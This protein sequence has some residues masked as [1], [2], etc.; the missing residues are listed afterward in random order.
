MQ[1]VYTE[2][3]AN[4]QGGTKGH[5]EVTDMSQRSSDINATA[6]RFGRISAEDEAENA[7]RQAFNELEAVPA[8]P[9]GDQRVEPGPE[10]EPEPPEKEEFHRRL[11]QLEKQNFRMKLSLVVLALI[12]GYLS[13]DQVLSQ[14]TIVRQTLMESRELKLLDNDGN[15]RLFL[16]MYSR[17]PVLQLLDSSGKPRMSLG[18][19]FDDTPFIDLSDKR[20]RTRATLELTENDE[21]ALRL[22]D[23][24]GESTFKIN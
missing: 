7:E 22:F 3:I 19:R 2:Q 8:E 17:V 6:E 11:G 21:P 5:P 15:P 20:G 9:A 18:M 24:N 14:S 1:R 4:V 12:V 23:E 13:F 16:R 10:H